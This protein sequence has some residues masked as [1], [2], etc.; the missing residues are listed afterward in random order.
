[1]SSDHAPDK[2]LPRVY[3]FTLE[4]T[5]PTRAFTHSCGT[6]LPGSAG[7]LVCTLTLSVTHQDTGSYTRLTVLKTQ[8]LTDTD[9]TARRIRLFRQTRGTRST[10]SC[11]SSSRPPLTPWCQ[12][13]STGR[14][15]GYVL[16]IP[17]YTRAAAVTADGNCATSC[18]S[19]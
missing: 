6:P 9:T 3:P 12:R 7:Y 17:Q 2:G 13:G 1:M 16:G 5:V 18:R 19:R 11:L 14:T 10:V 15:S 4:D 8:D